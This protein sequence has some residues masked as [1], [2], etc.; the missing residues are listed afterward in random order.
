MR[1]RDVDW[2]RHLAKARDERVA[3]NTVPSQNP[4]ETH[5]VWNVQNWKDNKPGKFYKVHLWWYGEDTFDASISCTC[6]AGQS[7]NPCKHAAWVAHE[8]GFI[9]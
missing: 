7:G 2:D 8:E 6:Y 9:D 1:L 5:K 4:S 3:G